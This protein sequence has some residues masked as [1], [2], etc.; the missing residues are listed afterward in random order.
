MLI[1]HINP[2]SLH[3]PP[4]HPSCRLGRR[5]PEGP[6][7]SLGRPPPSPPL[8][9]L[10]DCLLKLPD[11]HIQLHDLPIQV[12]ELPLHLEERI[13]P[14]LEILLEAEG[15]D[16]SEARDEGFPLA[17]ELPIAAAQLARIRCSIG[18]SLLSS[19]VVADVLEP[20]LHPRDRR[21]VRLEFSAGDVGE[22]LGEM[23]L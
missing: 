17:P 16:F 5:Q 21:Q 1:Y 3:P 12:I 11:P 2:S 4:P 15:E 8:L 6:N 19:G 7:G 20:P 14:Q 23:D 22:G 18:L 13:R 9:H 10:P